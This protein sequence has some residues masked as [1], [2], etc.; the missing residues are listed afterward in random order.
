MARKRPRTAG[1]KK[2]RRASGGYLWL[3]YLF[4]LGKDIAWKD[5]GECATA[6]SIPYS[7][8]KAHLNGQVKHNLDGTR[9]RLEAA[10]RERRIP[11]PAA[12][13][14][15]SLDKLQSFRDL[16]CEGVRLGQWRDYLNC[17]GKTGIPQRNIGKFSSPT[18]LG[19]DAHP[20]ERQTYEQACDKIRRFLRPTRSEHEEPSADHQNNGEPRRSRRSTRRQ[21]AAAVPEVPPAT[22]REEIMDRTPTQSTGS[23]ATPPV[24]MMPLL[25]KWLS[26][27]LELFGESVAGSVVAQ[28]VDKL[29]AQVGQLG[30]SGSMQPPQ[31]IVPS[32]WLDEL[33]AGKLE[34]EG[35]R[36]EDI[37]FIL[38]RP[39]FYQLPTSFTE[40]ELKRVAQFADM[41]CKLHEEYRRLLQ[42]LAQTRNVGHAATIIGAANKRLIQQ[43]VATVTMQVQYRECDLN[44][45]AVQYI[46]KFLELQQAFNPTERRSP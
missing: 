36:T 4:S 14:D 24:S 26:M 28:L 6:V 16:Y 3:E 17:A 19:S 38:F 8:F 11:I 10:L 22:T 39:P 15:H 27:G 2:A 37:R 25:L 29:P 12:E 31:G 21:E 30:T 33:I 7:T 46:K 9:E 20:R 18:P 45:T 34:I 1:R 13:E 32:N 43:E 44:E 35:Q 42:L 41:L 5:K 40:E 23:A